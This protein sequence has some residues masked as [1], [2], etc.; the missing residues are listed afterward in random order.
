MTYRVKKDIAQSFLTLTKQKDID[1][2]TVKDIVEECHI[3]RQTFY[4]H[5]QDIY[6]VFEWASEQVLN[7]TL[8]KSLEVE[9]AQEALS[10][11]IEQFMKEQELIQKMLHSQKRD[12]VEKGI[13]SAISKYI[14]EMF[15]A[16]VSKSGKSVKLQQKDIALC[17]YASGI[18]GVLIQ[19]LEK[20]KVDS[21]ELAKQLYEI[22]A[23]EIN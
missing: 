7:N 21:K 11:F 8:Q 9:N 18:A 2:I 19:N 5:F 12:F 4:Y 15:I 13:I 20:N 14:E 16:R 6:A 22:I 23:R 17:F 3:S 10:I 1:K